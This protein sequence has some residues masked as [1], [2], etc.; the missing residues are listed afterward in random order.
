MQAIILSR[1]M[2]HGVGDTVEFEYFRY[3]SAAEPYSYERTMI[4]DAVSPR[5]LSRFGTVERLF[6]GRITEM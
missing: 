1:L 3:E 4:L 6:A 2:V 5:I